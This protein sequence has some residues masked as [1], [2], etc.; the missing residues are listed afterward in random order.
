[1]NGAD[2]NS[3][4][5]WMLVIVGLVI[6]GIGRTVQSSK[7][8]LTIYYVTISYEQHAELWS[9]FKVLHSRLYLV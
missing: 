4:F 7:V 9:C 2:G 6:A 5:G 3:G 1:M 8:V